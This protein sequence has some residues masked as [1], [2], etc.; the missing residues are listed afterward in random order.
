MRAKKIA[1]VKLAPHRKWRFSQ[2]VIE[3]APDTQ[4]VYVL[5]NEQSPLGVG[6]AL[7]GGDTIQS[8]LRRHFEHAA[9]SGMPLATHYSWEICR[10]PL[11]R[12]AELALELRL[13]RRDPRPPAAHEDPGRTVEP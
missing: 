11:R 1:P 8:R 9:A 10:E 13:R 7:G 12:E 4:G 5:W 3:G 2:T 6:H